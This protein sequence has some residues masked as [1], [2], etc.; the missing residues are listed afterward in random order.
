MMDQF[1]H[2]LGKSGVTVYEFAK[3]YEDQLRSLFVNE[4]T[5]LTAGLQVCLELYLL[6]K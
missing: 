6:A 3:K 2:G 4:R 1:C 5:T